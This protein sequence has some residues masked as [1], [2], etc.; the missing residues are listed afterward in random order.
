MPS[1]GAETADAVVLRRISFKARTD[2]VRKKRAARKLGRPR[3]WAVE[4][5]VS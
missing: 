1:K 5:I 4:A 2:N 3:D